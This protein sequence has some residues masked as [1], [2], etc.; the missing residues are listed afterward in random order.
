LVEGLNKAWVDPLKEGDCVALPVGWKDPNIGT[1]PAKPGGGKLK[2]TDPAAI[3]IA[4]VYG[5]QTHTSAEAGASANF[6]EQQKYIWFSIR[7]RVEGAGYPPT[8]DKVLD[9]GQYHAIGTGDFNS[10]LDDLE[11]NDPPKLDG[12]KNAK[13]IVL[14]N[15]TSSVPADAGA[16][17]FHWT[18]DKSKKLN[19]CFAAANKAKPAEKEKNE[20]KCAWEWAKEIDIVGSV[21]K[22]DGWLKRIRG[23]GDDPIGTMYIYPGNEK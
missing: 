3:A 20:K 11:A 2:R 13:Q 18:K 1:L 23:S 14:D 10:A 22:D 8:L 17:Y 7:K 15:W 4:T 16:G 21:K 12:V 19:D 5:E 6:K 9:G